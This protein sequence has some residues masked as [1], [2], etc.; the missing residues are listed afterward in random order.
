MNICQ[1]KK[2]PTLGVSS[3]LRVTIVLRVSLRIPALGL[4][5]RRWRVSVADAFVFIRFR[6]EESLWQEHSKV[7]CIWMRK[8]NVARSDKAKV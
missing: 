8:K 7:K 2:R 5:R 1:E 3:T 6:G 4:V